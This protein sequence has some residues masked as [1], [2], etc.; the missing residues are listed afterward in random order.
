MK[1]KGN[2]KKNRISQL[3]DYF[4]NNYEVYRDHGGTA[5]IEEKESPDEPSRT[6]KI[7]SAEFKD[8]IR[9]K[10]YEKYKEIPTAGTINNCI[11]QL[12]ALAH[13][14][15]KVRDVHKR[16]SKPNDGDNIYI[17]TNSNRI[18]MINKE[19][20]RN[21]K[22]SK[23]RFL[24]PSTA[25]VLPQPDKDNATIEPLW[26]L[27]NLPDENDRI[28]LQALL[29]KAL[30]PS[31]PTPVLIINGP[32]NSGKSTMQNYIK[33]ILDPSRDTSKSIPDKK[34]MIIA[35]AF[36]CHV[37]AYDKIVNL[38]EDQQRELLYIS[39]HSSAPNSVF[40]KSSD[41]SVNR[42]MNP[43]I[44]NGRVPFITTADLFD[45][46]LV[47]NLTTIQSKDRDAKEELDTLF[48]ESKGSIF[49]W[50]VNSLQ[51]VLMSMDDIEMSDGLPPDKRHYCLVG[52]ALEPTLEWDS[53]SFKKAF[54]ANRRSGFMASLMDDPLT[55]GII[56]LLDADRLDPEGNTFQ[57]LADLL[58][59]VNPDCD[60]KAKG[61]SEGL[62]RIERALKGGYGI[63][64]NRIGKTRS[65]FKVKIYRK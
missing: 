23:C 63:I 40:N 24:L 41:S 44:L 38:T 53:G 27:L 64:I 52:L 18:I 28:M 31:T 25:E 55:F 6:V 29:L 9:I 60:L 11:N 51:Q 34:G 14:G 5:F 58:R 1:T 3:Y 2:A 45:R 12:K 35:D 37:L 10:F 46:C 16:V 59:D 50:L 48:E 62:K 32:K 30:I 17:N 13:Q 61:V 15:S 57:E 47:F 19:E 43:I 36:E 65:G 7:E 33:C 4:T 56:Q 54:K 8:F 26:R 49:G 42:L 22:N 39:T 20:R 21:F